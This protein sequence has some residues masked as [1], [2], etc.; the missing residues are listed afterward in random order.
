MGGRAA[1]EI[2]FGDNQISTGSGNDL[3]K[4]TDLAY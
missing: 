2:F 4:A 3:Q 1:E